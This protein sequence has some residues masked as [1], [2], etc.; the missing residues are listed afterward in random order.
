MSIVELDDKGRITIPKRMRRILGGRKVLLID[1][2]DRI[3]IIP[4]PEDPFETLKGSFNIEKP[5][6]ELRREAEILA[7]GEAGG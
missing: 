7:E 1:L 4:V 5:F 3:E 2:G 6:K